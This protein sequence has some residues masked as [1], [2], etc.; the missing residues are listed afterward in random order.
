MPALKLTPIDRPVFICTR[1]AIA[2]ALVTIC[3]WC[4]SDAAETTR[5]CAER[6]PRRRRIS[7]PSLLSDAQKAQLMRIESHDG[8]E[9]SDSKCII[10]STSTDA[11]NKVPTELPKSDTAGRDRSGASSP[12]KKAHRRRRRQAAVYSATDVMVTTVSAG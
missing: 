9:Q 5:F 2:N 11:R 7:A 12:T 6:K 8:A 1:C 10:A 3:P 4:L